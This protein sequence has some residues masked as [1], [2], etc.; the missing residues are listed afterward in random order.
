MTTPFRTTR[1]V[2]FSDTDMAGMV[3]FAN[4][5]R[6]MEAAEVELWRS[7]GLSVVLG[8]QQ[9]KLSFPRVSASCDFSKPAYFEDLLDIAVSIQRLGNKSVTFSFEFSKG[10]EV[11]ARGQITAVCCRVVAGSPLEAVEIPAAIR[12]RLQ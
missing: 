10:A 8:Q 6:Y 12:E 1:R 9:E 5:F 3:H 7:R 4:F 11:I 2:E